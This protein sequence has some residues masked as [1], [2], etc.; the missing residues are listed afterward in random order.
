MIHKVYLKYP[1]GKI[2]EIK[3]P[4]YIKDDNGAGNSILPGEDKYFEYAKKR[5]EINNLKVIEE[6]VEENTCI[7]PLSKFISLSRKIRS[8]EK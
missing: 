1:C 7:Q 8:I 2:F 4:I 5:F 6:L 3:V